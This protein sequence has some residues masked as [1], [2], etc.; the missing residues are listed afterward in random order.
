MKKVLPILLTLAIL[1]TLLGLTALADSNINASGWPIVNEKVTLRVM[2]PDDGLRKPFNELKLYQEYEE[3][4]NVHIEWVMVPSSDWSEKLALMLA[5]GDSMPDI[6]LGGLSDSIVRE[7]ASTG[8]FIAMDEYIDEYAHNLLG[9]F[10]QR[11]SLR[12]LWSALDGKMYQLG[13]VEEM[14]GLVLTHGTH[15]INKAWLDKFGL[16]VPTTTEEYKNALLTFLEND[17]NGNGVRDEI[18]FSFLDAG[19]AVWRN[20]GSF[21]AL[22]G[23]FGMPDTGDHI[24]VKDGKVYFTAAQESYKEGIEYFRDLYELGLVDPESFS[25]TELQLIAKG[26]AA[27][28]LLGSFIK[29]DASHCVGVER[30]EDYVALAPLV[31]PEGHQ[32]WTRE[33]LTELANAKN[34]AV[35]T[36][37]CEYPEIAIRWLD[38]GFTPEISV[39]INWGALGEVYELDEEGV[40]KN[41]PLKEGQDEHTRRVN[42]TP[43]RNPH[44][45]LSEYYDTIVRYPEDAA[46]VYAIRVEKQFPYA[47][48]EFYPELNFTEEET[49]RVSIILTDVYSIVDEYRAVW[50][51]D[52]GVENQWGQYLKELEDAGLSEYLEIKQSAYDKYLASIG[53]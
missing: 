26:N 24:Y 29:W 10:E 27:D 7:N 9:L 21:G 20:H 2:T 49:T 11:P 28:E 13:R 43:S 25:Q 33:N 4:T 53:Q 46:G 31:G 3:A 5:T 1:T 8:N 37:A 51:M 36:K 18:G 35:I 15:W 30:A 45:I 32:E 42:S 38:Y 52:G 12:T 50:I 14:Y 40:M 34:F 22:W 48:E 16:D 47:N 39:Q 19:S 44:I 41:A 23:S 6:I 17:A